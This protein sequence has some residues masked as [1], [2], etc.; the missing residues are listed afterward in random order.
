VVSLR[1]WR[2]SARGEAVCP[3]G[4]SYRKR[5]EASKGTKPRGAT[6][7]EVW[8]TTRPTDR[9]LFGVLHPEGEARTEISVLNPMR[10]RR[11]T[12]A[13]GTKEG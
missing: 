13:Y 3:Q 12:R 10:E 6:D 4:T 1:P 5:Q 11:S 9:A 8:L 7:G 2:E